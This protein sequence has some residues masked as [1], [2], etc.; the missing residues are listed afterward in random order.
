MGGGW[1]DDPDQQIK[2]EC[3]RACAG[4]R[5]DV[6]PMISLRNTGTQQS[7]AEPHENRSDQRSTESKA[8]ERLARGVQ[9]RRGDRRWLRTRI[10]EESWEARG[11]NRWAVFTSASPEM[12]PKSVDQA[13]PEL[14]TAGEAM[15]RQDRMG[16][17]GPNWARWTMQAPSVGS[18]KDGG[19]KGD[20]VPEART[21]PHPCSVESRR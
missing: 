4:R 20:E 6:P 15:Y 10:D 16:Q 5:F 2:C 11:T 12:H 21:G 1:Q 18:E 7:T 14:C 17:N 13:G 9:G 3:A 8:K 19:V